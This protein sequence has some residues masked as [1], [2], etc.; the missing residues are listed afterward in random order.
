MKLR[1]LGLTASLYLTTIRNL[2]PVQIRSRLRRLFR[3]SARPDCPSQMTVSFLSKEWIAPIEA[4]ICAAPPNHF[5][6]LNRSEELTFPE[7]WDLSGLPKLWLY[8]LHYF[9]WLNSVD[10]KH[11]VEWHEQ[12]IDRWI[13]ENRFPNGNGW[14]PYP[15]S[16]RVVNWIKWFI[17]QSSVRKEHL[18]SLSLQIAYLSANTET[19]ILGNHYFAN[20]KAL[21]F[22][23]LFFQGAAAA[24]WTRQGEKILEQQLEEQILSDGAHFELSPMYHS[25]ILGDVLD[26]INVYQAFGEQRLFDLEKIANKMIE[27]LLLMSHP[28]GDIAYFNDASINIAPNPSSLVRYA[29]SLSESKDSINPGWLALSRTRPSGGSGPPAPRL[30]TMNSSGYRRVEMD[31]ATC[32]VD[33]AEIGPSYLPGHAHADTLSF[34]LSIENRRVVVNSGCSEYDISGVRAFE[35]GT[36]A[37]STARVDGANSS[38]VWKSFRVARRAKIVNRAEWIEGDKVNIMAEHNG[39][40]RLK[41]KPNH[42]RVWIAEPRSLQIRDAF[43]GRLKHRIEIFF[44][45]HPEVLVKKNGFN[46]FTLEAGGRQIGLRI[47]SFTNDEACIMDSHWAQ[48]FGVRR[49][50]KTIVFTAECQLPQQFTTTFAW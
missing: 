15:T 1:N 44:P 45:I 5:V 9:D 14:E 11:N 47:D 39:F 37:H 16:L 7:G 32:I 40:G 21:I 18:D 3:R 34:E 49:P 12:I 17:D 35:R 10:S 4:P 42:K 26:L 19:H 50:S 43:H 29:T 33:C 6:F 41:G 2:S 36:S 13:A 23:G 22:G 24:A 38:E 20:A 31:S 27:W 30:Y 28:D 48:E 8:N 25:I 46:A